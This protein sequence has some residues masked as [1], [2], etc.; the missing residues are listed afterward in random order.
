[1][2]NTKCPISKWFT[3]PLR[4][5]GNPKSRKIH[6]FLKVNH[7]EIGHFVL[8]IGYSFSTFNYLLPRKP[9]LPAFRR[10]GHI[11]TGR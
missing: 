10:H 6:L 8:V 2:T 4:E 9:A 1:M 11:H 5:D 3:F 7:L